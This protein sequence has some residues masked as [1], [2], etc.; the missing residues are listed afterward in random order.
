MVGEGAPA[1][2]RTNLDSPG[3]T[4]RSLSALSLDGGLIE[5]ALEEFLSRVAAIARF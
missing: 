1:M 3:L 5:K 4:E 2:P